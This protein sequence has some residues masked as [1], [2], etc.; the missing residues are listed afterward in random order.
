MLQWFIRFCRIYRMHLHVGK[1]EISLYFSTLLHNANLQSVHAL[2]KNI[3]KYFS[4]K[5]CYSNSQCRRSSKVD[6]AQSEI[7]STF[8]S[9]S[10]ILAWQ[11]NKFPENG[12]VSLLSMSQWLV[13]MWSSPLT[14]ESKQSNDRT[15]RNKQSLIRPSEAS[16]END[17]VSRL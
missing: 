12:L 14:K 3:C 7:Q 10:T 13:L 17:W 8:K 16:K 11:S 15:C 5:W 4:S 6:L 9:R 2:Y 1:T